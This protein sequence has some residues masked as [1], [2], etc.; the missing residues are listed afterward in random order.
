MKDEDN[1]PHF[2]IEGEGEETEDEEAGRKKKIAKLFILKGFLKPFGLLTQLSTFNHLTTLIRILVS[3]TIS[4]C[5][6]PLC[7]DAGP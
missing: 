1:L 2:D 7:L 5:S 6:A 4:S 3:L